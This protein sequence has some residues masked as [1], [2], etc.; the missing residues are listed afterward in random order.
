M[1]G[2]V[3][4]GLRGLPERRLLAALRLKTA[5]H[6]PALRRLSA[7][8]RLQALQILCTPSFPG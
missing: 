3:G 7:V 2:L 8:V 6:T 1:G 4:R 5:L